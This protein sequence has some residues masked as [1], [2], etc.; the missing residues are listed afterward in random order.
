MYKSEAVE[1]FVHSTE[2]EKLVKHRRLGAPCILWS[3]MSLR[4]APMQVLV[5]SE[6]NHLLRSSSDLLSGNLKV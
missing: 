2:E 3:V 5:V 1:R 4:D 6:L